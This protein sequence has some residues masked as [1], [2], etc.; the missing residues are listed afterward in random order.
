VATLALPYCVEIDQHA[1]HDTL[2]HACKR[3]FGTLAYVSAARIL[4]RIA[5]ESRTQRVAEEVLLCMQTLSSM[6]LSEH[7]LQ[8]TL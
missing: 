6:T 8:V 1:A 3:N 5:L 4:L 2:K 7:P